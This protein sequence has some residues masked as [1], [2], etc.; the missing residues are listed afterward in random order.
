M[1]WKLQLVFDSHDPDEIIRFWGRALGYDSELVRM[2][3]EQLREWRKDFP[4]YDGRGRVDDGEARRMPVYIQQVPEPKSG[5]NRVRPQI[6]VRDDAMDDV[7]SE[8]LAL[9]ATET[10]DGFADVEGNEFTVVGGLDAT[11]T[12]RMLRSIV[13]DCLEPDR[14]LEFWSQATGYIPGDGRCD[15]VPDSARIE[16]GALFVHGERIN[17]V[18]APF[19][20]GF[21]DPKDMPD[22]VVLDLIPGLAFRKVDEPKQT[23]NRLHIDMHTQ[24]VDGDRARIE[25]LGATVQQW[26]TEHVLLDPEGNEFCLG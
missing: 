25:K 21:N 7:R 12:D 14:M 10:A 20:L 1:I 9:G 6:A 15:P 16:S 2:E 17:D 13:I 3:A 26:D 19:G 22:R 8:L 23:K 18:Q 11:D 5:P 24:D 4:Q